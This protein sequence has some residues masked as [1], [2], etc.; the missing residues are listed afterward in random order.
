MYPLSDA[1]L[2]AIELNPGDLVV[3]LLVVAMLVL[4]VG[5]LLLGGFR[6]RATARPILF[7][8]LFSCLYGARLAVSLSIFEAIPG[9]RPYVTAEI[10]QAMTYVV[11][12]PLMLLVQEF[13]GRGWR[14]TMR[15]TV[16][17]QVV[18]TGLGVV[19]AFVAPVRDAFALAKPYIVIV[20]GLAALVNILIAWRQKDTVPTSLAVGFSVFFATVGLFNLALIM[21]W[22]TFAAAEVIGYVALV[23]ALA[24]AIAV[25]TLDTETRLRLIDREVQSAQRIQS[26]I[27]PQVVPGLPGLGVTV[28]YRPM[29]TVAGDFYDFAPIDDQRVG[30]L[31]A[32][33]LGHG[34]GAALIASMVKIAF[35]SAAT[36]AADPAAVLNGINTTLVEVLSRDRDY[37]TAS[38]VVASAATGEIVYSQAGHP[39]PLLVDPA[40]DVRALTEGGTILGQFAWARYPCARVAAAAGSRLLLYTDG[41]TEA[42]NPAGE[43]YGIDRL[44]H[45]LRRSRNIGGSECAELLLAELAGWRGVDT[46]EDDVTVIFVDLGSPSVHAAA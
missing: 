42:M 46:V 1:T 16:W 4:G 2:F 15:A 29:T 19:S 34:I 31:I 30:I 35:T 44:S 13:I 33:V 32:D 7:F 41:V 8:G 37:V 24:Y 10:R 40:G 22:S 36:S 5:A 6:P 11:L 12:L 26:G 23:G 39:P 21:R 9:I 27:L 20:I 45:F 3:S 14:G 43:M 38:Y 18:Y 25:Y 17:L 28:R